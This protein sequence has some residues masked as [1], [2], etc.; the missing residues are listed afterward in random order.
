LQPDPP[1]TADHAARPTLEEIVAGVIEGDRGSTERFFT[2]AATRV[3]SIVLR[4]LQD[5]GIWVDQNRLH[6]IV[7]D[8]ILELVRTAPSWRPD[9]GAA[10]WNWAHGRLVAIAFG[11]LG[12]FAD[13]LDDHRALED[14]VSRTC[15][16]D[17]A[18][19]E[20]LAGLAS[21]H[22]TL[23]A[24]C[25]ALAHVASDR[26]GRVWV[27]LIWE[28]SGGNRRAAVTV[29]QNHGLS[30]A[31]VRKIRQR[32]QRSLVDLRDHDEYATLA[33]LPVLSA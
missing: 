30:H 26:D 1:A 11:Q 16:V 23:A 28:E 22:P 31:N 18:P 14:P 29:A 8:C 7:Q 15:P 2:V 13:D 3:R 27:D 20:V 25:R 9:G 12:I 10:P 6:D 19:H 32:V 33:A 4:A 5:A 21:E 24:L 17:A